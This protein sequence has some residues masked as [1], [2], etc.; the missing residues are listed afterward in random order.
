MKNEMTSIGLFE[1]TSISDGFLMTDYIL[2]GSNVRLLKNEIMCPGKY[3]LLIEGDLR[4]VTNSINIAKEKKMYSM[5]KS[6]IIAKISSKVIEGINKKIEGNKF[7]AVGV[8]ET[9]NYVT[10]L[11]LADLMFKNSKIEINRILDRYGIFGK[12]IVIYSGSTSEVNNANNFALTSK[13]K[14]NIVRTNTIHKPISNYFN[15]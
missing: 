14:D 5:K 4:A 6:E 15:I 11:V 8:L 1:F 3:V 13:Y 7:D 12:G 10:A 9:K 2:K